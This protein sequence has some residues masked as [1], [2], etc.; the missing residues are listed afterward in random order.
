MSVSRVL[1]CVIAGCAAVL[2]VLGLGGR[3]SA[4]VNGQLAPNA[5]KRFD[6]VGLFFSA[7]PWTCAGWVSG[8]C[9][10]V[11]PNVVLVARHSLGIASSDPLPLLSARPFRVRFRRAANG[12]SENSQHSTTF[13]ISPK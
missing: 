13:P 4:V 10:L 1:C 3:A 6:A 11:G 2:G 5:D 12:L 9:T 7:T 8:S